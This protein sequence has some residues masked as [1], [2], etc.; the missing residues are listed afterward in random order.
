MDENETT[1]LAALLV[2]NEEENTCSVSKISTDQKY[3]INQIRTI[4]MT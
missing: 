3:I 4:F 1:G 2:Y